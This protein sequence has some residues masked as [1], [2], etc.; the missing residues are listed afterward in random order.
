[1][2]DDAKAY[3]EFQAR[4]FD[5]AEEGRRL[6]EIAAAKHSATCICHGCEAAR[7]AFEDGINCGCEECKR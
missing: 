2:K 6:D 1:M 5:S 3:S 4:V 7:M